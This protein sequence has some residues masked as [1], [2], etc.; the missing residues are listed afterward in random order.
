MQKI[1]SIR[2]NGSIHTPEKAD[3]SFL[4][5]NYVSNSVTECLTALV[6]FTILALLKYQVSTN[7][8]YLL[9]PFAIPIISLVRT[10][11]QD[12]PYQGK[13]G[14]YFH[15]VLM[16]ATFISSFLHL[17][18]SYQACKWISFVIGSTGV[19]LLICQIGHEWAGKNEGA[20]AHPH[21]RTIFKALDIHWILLRVQLCI[22]PLVIETLRLAD[23]TR[24]HLSLTVHI[25]ILLGAT[26]CLTS[27]FP[28][29]ISMDR[30]VPEIR[31]WMGWIGL[32]MAKQLLQSLVVILDG[33]LGPNACLIGV[34]LP[35]S[36]VLIWFVWLSCRSTY[37][38]REGDENP[39]QPALQMKLSKPG[40]SPRGSK[41]VKTFCKVS[42]PMSTTSWSW[43]KQMS[44]DH[45][46]FDEEAEG[47][48]K[49]ERRP[50][51]KSSFGIQYNSEKR[52]V[53]FE[54]QLKEVI[55]DSICDDGSSRFPKQF[56]ISPLEVEKIIESATKKRLIIK[57][58]L[59]PRRS[60]FTRYCNESLRNML[61]LRGLRNSDGVQIPKPIEFVLKVS[62]NR[63]REFT[64]NEFIEGLSFESSQNQMEMAGK[65]ECSMDSHLRSF[66]GQEEDDSKSVDAEPEIRSIDN[67]NLGEVQDRQKRDAEIRSFHKKL[68]L[69]IE[70]ERQWEWKINTPRNLHEDASSKPENRNMEVLQSFCETAFKANQ[71]S[72][73]ADIDLCLKCKSKKA[74]V[75]LSPCFHFQ[76]CLDCTKEVLRRKLECNRCKMA[77][78]ALLMIDPKYQA[79]NIY[80]VTE[81]LF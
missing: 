28:S 18:Y 68:C 29:L 33:Y 55:E 59:R 77:V 7:L 70:L 39:K 32:L 71:Q 58:R 41:L 23:Q 78:T 9:I 67:F 34:V 35:S 8:V 46:N 26:V 11:C 31:K 4:S 53:T 45:L 47:R 60:K 10:I 25:P 62:E 56:I 52:R 73:E 49:M 72:T 3:N 44:E 17:Q 66:Y 30:S 76:W 6:S 64:L 1:N 19:L 69:P 57:E 5:I 14:E 75:V 37:Q 74:C 2:T 20:E 80:K 40:I 22:Y 13:A 16:T 61:K 36:F 51:N 65:L 21:L 27:G 79:K 50:P 12:N 48:N 54:I 42:S 63:M 38:I 81:V 43:M 15:L 24:S